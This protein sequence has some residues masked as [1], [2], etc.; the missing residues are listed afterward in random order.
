MSKRSVMRR[1]I[2]GAVATAM[3]AAIGASAP[4]AE[5]QQYQN[6][7]SGTG[8]GAVGGA[9]IGGEI[10]FLGLSAF[11][12]KSGWLYATVP[13]A[14]A[15]GGGIGGYYIEKSASPE[16][17]M[18]ML[19]GG[20][21]LIIPT[22][23]ITLTATSYGSEEPVVI[24]T[25]TKGAPSGGTMKPAESGGPSTT[26]GQPSVPVGTSPRSQRR[27]DPIL[28]RSFA[29]VNFDGGDSIRWSVPAVQVRPMYS[30]V[31]QAQ[32]GVSQKVQV[33]APIVA[34]NF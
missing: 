1:A 31:E 25:G 14:L 30:R 34:F 26:G 29:L 4:D 8:K 6:P 19:A 11:G 23:V 18:Y 9:L 10:G 21:A 32:F 22:V 5:A 2:C 13:A 24:D 12:A 15:I 7:V 27:V 17:S 33:N 16:V 28:A 3:L 20:M